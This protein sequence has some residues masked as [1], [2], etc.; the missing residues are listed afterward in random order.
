MRRLVIL[1]LLAVFSFSV[2]AAGNAD[3]GKAKSATCSACHGAAGISANDLWPNLA[4]QKEGYLV[5]QIKAF[6][7]GD[8]QDPS[9][10]PMVGALSD[11]DI[12][13]IAAYYSNL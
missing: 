11:Q 13:D 12:E 5:K 1:A 8:R 6:K 4:G 2:N 9:M 7:N 3:A 10:A